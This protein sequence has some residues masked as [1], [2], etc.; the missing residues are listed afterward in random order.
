MHGE[1]MK[2]KMCLDEV[3][4][5]SRLAIGI[6]KTEVNNLYQLKKELEE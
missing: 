6:L 4:N 5:M 3:K 2:L 1:T